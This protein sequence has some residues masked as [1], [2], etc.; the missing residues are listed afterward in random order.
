MSLLDLG[1]LYQGGQHQAEEMIQ[2]VNFL[3]HKHGVW[4]LVSQVQLIGALPV[5]QGRGAEKEA[6]EQAVS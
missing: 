5:H 1:L 6:S 4:R 3:L 2:W